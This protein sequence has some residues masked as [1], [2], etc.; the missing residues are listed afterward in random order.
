MLSVRCAGLPCQ[1]AVLV[2]RVGLTCWSVELVCRPEYLMDL[3]GRQGLF[4][5]PLGSSGLSWTGLAP[6]WAVLGLSWAVLG[7]SG[8]SLGP[9]WSSL[10]AFCHTSQLTHAPRRL[11]PFAPMACKRSWLDSW[12]RALATSALRR[13]S[14]RLT[15]ACASAGRPRAQ[16][17]LTRR[18]PRTR[19]W[20]GGSASWEA[21]ATPRTP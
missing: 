6:S 21:A 1:S 13:P 5:I 9:C 18:C 15:R 17:G 12:R 7:P 3:V 4:G 20:S 2:S 8:G 19:P 14:P 16:T 10:G 11:E